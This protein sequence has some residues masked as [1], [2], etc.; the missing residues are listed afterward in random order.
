MSEFDELLQR[1]EALTGLRGRDA[2]QVAFA[3]DEGYTPTSA[4]IVEAAANAGFD[5]EVKHGRTTK[6][7]TP[8]AEISMDPATVMENV[9]W[10]CPRL[11]PADED[12]KVH[13]AKL[14]RAPDELRQYE[15][16]EEIIDEMPE[17]MRAVLV[18]IDLLEGKAT[19]WLRD[20]ANEIDRPIGPIDLSAY[21]SERALI[22]GLGVLFKRIDR[23]LAADWN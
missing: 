13:V 9:Y 6:T 18:K 3:F 16:F 19:F 10:A 22:E 20:G 2:A 7:A 17:E 21:D 14:G 8:I 12:G 23:V 4:E 5:V 15:G 1:I 11:T